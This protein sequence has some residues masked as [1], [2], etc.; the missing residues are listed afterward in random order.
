MIDYENMKQVV[1]ITAFA[2]IML[3]DAYVVVYW[4][5]KGAKWLWKK[6]RK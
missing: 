6:V 3:W 2:A 4:V 5:V 1:V